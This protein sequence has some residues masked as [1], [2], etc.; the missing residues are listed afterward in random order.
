MSYTHCKIQDI[1]P[2]ALASLLYSYYL[3]MS[4]FYYIKSFFFYSLLHGSGWVLIKDSLSSQISSP[5]SK[6]ILMFLHWRVFSWTNMSGLP[7]H[8]LLTLKGLG[9]AGLCGR[10]ICH[11]ADQVHSGLAFYKLSGLALGGRLELVCDSM[12]GQM[13]SLLF[14]R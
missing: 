13:I 4:K 1:L 12:T 5:S 10:W 2:P 6:P 14:Q 11:C 8:S 9:E 3:Y 7:C